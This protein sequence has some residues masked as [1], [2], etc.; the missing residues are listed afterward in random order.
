MR[1]ADLP[2]SHKTPW[3]CSKM[4]KAAR[5]TKFLKR[6]SGIVIAL[7]ALFC[8]PGLLA[9]TVTGTITG[10][11]TDASGAVVSG[12]KVVAHNT[13]TSVDSTV[14]T[15]AVGLYRIQFLPIGRYE[16]TVD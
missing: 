4:N 13:N 15:N 5:N 16:V 9:Q 11:V 1:D 3:S 8:A 7:A 6:I 10:N 12:A 2:I 14:T